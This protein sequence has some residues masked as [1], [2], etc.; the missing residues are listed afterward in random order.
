LH[1]GKSTRPGRGG[2]MAAGPAEVGGGQ[3]GLP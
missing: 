1:G 3:G 2:G